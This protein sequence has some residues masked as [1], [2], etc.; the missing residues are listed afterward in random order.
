MRLV[1]RVD[2]RQDGFQL[3]ISL[4]AFL[5]KPAPCSITRFIEVQMRRR[6]VE[7]KRIIGGEKPSGKADPVLIGSIAR[8]R[9]WLEE[10]TSGVTPTI[11]VIA[12]REG[13]IGSY[14][15]R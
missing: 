2:L 7:M 15:L 14:V 12:K 13:V 8:A 10:L 4:T 3:T 6:G 9:A 1:Q 11:E 5:P